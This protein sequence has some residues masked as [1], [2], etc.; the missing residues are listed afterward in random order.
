MF[1]KLNKISR[2]TDGSF[3]LSEVRINASHILFISENQEMHKSLREGK[4][5]IGLSSMARFSDISLASASGKETITV[6][7]PPD[8]VESKINISNKQ[9]LRG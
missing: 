2:H 9:L 3:Y 1:I 6:V 5:Q 7:G 4:I 8:V